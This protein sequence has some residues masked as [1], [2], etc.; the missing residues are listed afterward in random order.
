MENAIAKDIVKGLLTQTIEELDEPK[1]CIAHYARFEQPFL[2]DLLQPEQLSQLPF[3]LVCTYEIARR[4]FPNLPS[5]GIRAVAGYFGTLCGQLKRSG[6]H[7][8]A[9]LSI[10]QG[11]QDHLIAQGIGSVSGLASWNQEPPK[12]RRTK[13]E[14]PLS[15]SKRLELPD[16]P[17]IYRMLSKKN[18]ILYVGKATSLKQRVNSYFRGQK[19]KDTKTRELLSQVWDISF[20]PCTTA[21][22]AALMETDEIKLWD[23]PY[24][25]A[26]KRRERMLVFYTHDFT[27]CSNSQD[28][29]H[30]VG[31]FANP[32]VIEPLTKLDQSLRANSFMEDIFH[33]QLP[34][35]L[36]SEGFELFC[37]TE[38]IERS[39]IRD[40]RSLL[41]LGLWLLRRK[42]R[43]QAA[44]TDPL[45][46]Q[47]DRETDPL[48]QQLN[49]ETDP[50]SQQLD[51]ETEALPESLTAQS[52]PLTA[53]NGLFTAEEVSTKYSR[54]LR[55]IARLYLRSK[56]LTRLLRTRVHYKQN[57]VDRTF[58]V[59]NGSIMPDH[60][61]VPE[62]DQPSDAPWRELDVNTYDR[63]SV[64]LTELSK[65]KTHSGSS[66]SH[67][68]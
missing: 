27:S 6:C 59:L 40:A 8:S 1:T 7:A 58:A 14:Y 51:R 5:R 10:W 23:P 61:L 2:L 16:V 28:G 38:G 35:V 60:L 24:N 47:L 46:Q 37:I 4:L 57:N 36:L 62:Q 42:L 39:E 18:T 54:M 68:T 12:S 30:F 50:L 55:R 11:L 9:T 21:L 31:P 19:G 44:E 64:L 32:K 20:T 33:N 17:G 25:R 67:L 3:E 49:R 52:G 66:S 48:A 41:A 22:E 15:K 45:T 13:Y 53:A 65:M 63:M 56:S 34:Q 29:L 43:E 26:L